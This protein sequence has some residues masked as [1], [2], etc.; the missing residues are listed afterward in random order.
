MDGNVG[1]I[2]IFLDC[3]KVDK[4]YIATV[5]LCLQYNI[6]NCFVVGTKY[7]SCIK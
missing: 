7:L 2:F 3:D 6:D 4:Y 5:Y 1:L